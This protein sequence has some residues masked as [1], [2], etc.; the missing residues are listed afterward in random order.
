MSDPLREYL[1]KIDEEALNSDE[2]SF[3]F[4]S[5]YAHEW[6]EGA[7]ISMEGHNDIDLCINDIE[8]TTRFKVNDVVYKARLRKDSW[9]TGLQLDWTTIEVDG[10]SNGS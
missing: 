9:G 1:T 6:I 10:E 8:I 3:V 2:R 7:I 5:E 4:P